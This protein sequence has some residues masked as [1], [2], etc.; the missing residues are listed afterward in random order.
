MF[1]IA[2]TSTAQAIDTFPFD[3]PV[4]NP[5]Y[6][7]GLTVGSGGDIWFILGEP[8]RIMRISDDRLEC[9]FN[10]EVP[11]PAVDLRVSP[12]GRIYID[13]CRYMY[14]PDGGLSRTNVVVP[15]EDVDYFY[16]VDVSATFDA[17]M[18]IYCMWHSYCTV[19]WR[20]LPPEIWEIV[21]GEDPVPR[22]EARWETTLS[23]PLFV[24]IN[25]C[26]TIDNSRHRP[27]RILEID[28][29]AG[30]IT[31]EHQA[32]WEHFGQISA[33][34]SNGILWFAGE[35][36]IVTFDGEELS[37]FAKGVFD[38]LHYGTPK[39]TADW[40]VWARQGGYYASLGIARFANG[41]KQSFTV[42]DGLLTDACYSL[43]IDYDGRVWFFNRQR[44]DKYVLGVSRIADGGWPPMRLMLHELETETTI[45]VEAQVINNGPVVGVDVYVAVEL[46]GQ[47]L[48]WPN[49]EPEPYP[50]QINLRPGYNQTATII[51][52]PR[53]SIPPGAYTFYACMTGRGTQKLIGPLDRKFETLTVEVGDDR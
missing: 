30:A 37:V 44:S 17:D 34:D 4:E 23:T 53:T 13:D 5:F 11:G 51:S 28:L 39:L 33:K 46:N 7:S 15:W 22:Y 9:M 12:D 10:T 40:T 14:S 38:E 1:G 49:W 16:Y 18:R 20:P 35:M 6:T 25:E 21:P 3:T 29:C 36:D 31:T 42:D 19:P 26:W 27:P 50:I 32:D 8:N 52:A 43:L 48:Y 47:L 2:T 24:S 41:E 45:A